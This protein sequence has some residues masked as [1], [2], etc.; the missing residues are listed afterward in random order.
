MVS[1]LRKFGLAVVL[2]AAVTLSAS[3]PCCHGLTVT[4]LGQLSSSLSSPPPATLTYTTDKPL[5]LVKNESRFLPYTLTSFS[6]GDS[7]SFS[8]SGVS[9]LPS[10]LRFKRPVV[11]GFGRGS[12]KLGFATANLEPPFP[13][14]E[15]MPRGVYCGWVRLP[16]STKEIPMVC[17]VGVNP[18][19]EDSTD[20]TLEVHLLG[21]DGGDFY[22]DTVDAFLMAYIR[23]EM[24]RVCESDLTRMRAS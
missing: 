9:M 10:F 15:D 1:L 20:V 2:V 3:L 13:P 24:V 12:A 7:Y 18:T 17:N 5:T 6:E 19:F 14:P 23:P 22:G 21:Y 11:R 16:S 4:D 8:Y